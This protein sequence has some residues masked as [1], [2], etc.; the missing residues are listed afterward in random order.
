MQALRD[1]LERASCALTPDAVIVGARGA[2]ACANT[3]CIAFPGSSAE[4]LVIKLDLAGIAVSAG[5]ACSSGKVGASRVL[6][7]MGL[8]PEIARGADPR[9][10]RAGDDG[11]GYRG[12]PRGLARRSQR[13]DGTRKVA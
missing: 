11:A 13:S 9:Q 5:A 4:T 8:A 7:A 6:A 3:S 10:H 12:I 2:S 1:R